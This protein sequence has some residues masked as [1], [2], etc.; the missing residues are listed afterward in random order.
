M[1]A[2]RVCQRT[3]ATRHRPASRAAPCMRSGSVTLRKGQLRTPHTSAR[4]P[5]PR[6]HPTPHYHTRTLPRS[7]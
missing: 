2:G 7:C 5:P 4:A 6:P 1:A 3:P